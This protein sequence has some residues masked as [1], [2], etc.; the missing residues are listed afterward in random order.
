MVGQ[1]CRL[2]QPEALM[3]FLVVALLLQSW[4]LSCE[5]ESLEGWGRARGC[6]RLQSTATR[7]YQQ[8][9]AR[10]LKPSAEHLHPARSHSG[11]AGA[12]PPPPD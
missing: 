7:L 1:R 10:A 5:E 4:Q 2:L 6:E 12:Q 9:S 8:T 3:L 11:G